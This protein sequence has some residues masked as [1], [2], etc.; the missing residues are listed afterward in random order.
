MV[1]EDVLGVV[2][3]VVEV[4]VVYGVD[5]AE[6]DTSYIC[7]KVVPTQVDGGAA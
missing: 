4:H 6:Y 1:L 3:D 2:V 5:D 7:N